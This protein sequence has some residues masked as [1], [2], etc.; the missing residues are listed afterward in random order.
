LK[1]YI[2]KIEIDPSIAAEHPNVK[3]LTDELSLN[4][5]IIYLKEFTDY[6]RIEKA[7]TNCDC[8]VAFIDEYWTSSTWKT[9]ELTFANGDVGSGLTDNKIINSKPTFLYLLNTNLESSFIDNYDGPI[10]LPS[11]VNPH[12]SPIEFLSVI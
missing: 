6:F 4:N 8:L 12:F 7:I 10:R 1:I 11:N 9:S 5:E 2:S 3:K